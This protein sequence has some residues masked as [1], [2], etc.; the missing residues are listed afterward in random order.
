MRGAVSPKRDAGVQPRA[1]ALLRA[2]GLCW[3][4]RVRGGP[5]AGGGPESAPA[6]GG[7]VGG[8]DRGARRGGCRPLLS[9]AWD[10]GA[11]R[12][13]DFRLPEVREGRVSFDA[14]GP[15]GRLSG[16]P[17]GRRRKFVSFL[18]LPRVVR[19]LLLCSLMIQQARAWRR[20]PPGPA[21]VL[22]A[23]HRR[24]SPAPA[25][26]QHKNDAEGCA[27]AWGKYQLTM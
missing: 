22:G 2:R 10:G 14:T 24:G 4:V 9:G 12:Q 3:R 27:A 17:G 16:R 6:A 18:G 23:P 15:R 19:R 26:R 11:A 20:R 7:G 5:T 21:G 1:R 8:S 13:P 25:R